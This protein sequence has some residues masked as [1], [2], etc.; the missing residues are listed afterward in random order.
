MVFFFE[1]S[2]FFFSFLLMNLS[3]IRHDNDDLFPFRCANTITQI[4]CNGIKKVHSFSAT[5]SF[6]DTVKLQEKSMIDDTS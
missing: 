3:C 1:K 2:L 4:D 6:L 5:M